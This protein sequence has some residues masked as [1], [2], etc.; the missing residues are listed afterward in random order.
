MPLELIAEQ[1]GKQRYA[2]VWVTNDA[3]LRH[4]ARGVFDGHAVGHAER[5]VIAVQRDR[6]SLT[7]CRAQASALDLAECIANP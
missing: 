7:H 5:L 3:V 2:A 1:V 6:V 4:D